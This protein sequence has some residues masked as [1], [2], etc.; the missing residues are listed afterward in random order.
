MKMPLRSRRFTLCA[1]DFGQ[2]RPINAAIIELIRVWRIGATSA[3]SQGPA[4]PEG[5]RALRDYQQLTDVGLHLNLTH[6]F[7][8]QKGTRPLAWW[9][10]AAPRGWIKREQV[11]DS[12]LSQIDLFFTHFGRL[13]DYLD[14]HQ[15]V[16]A[17]PV[18][19]EVTTEL[20]S[21]CWRGRPRPWVRTPDCLLDSGDIALKGWVL[22]RAARG[23]ADHVARDGLR[24]TKKFA[25]LYSL[26][27]ASDYPKL[28]RR[29]LHQLPSGTMLMCHPGHQTYD[30]NDP[31]REARYAEYQYLN[32]RGLSD[33]CAAADVSLVKFADLEAS[34]PSADSR[35]PAT[36]Y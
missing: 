6:R 25:G 22:K 27:P 34:S 11:R 5:A 26:D 36:R 8:G 32:Y 24:H 28:M 30:L 21:E 35:F 29:W 31:I 14:G 3:M 16:H 2:S 33:D 18:I 20:I 7:D 19:R 12:F 17:F 10:L 1:E 15:H 4:W 9:L 13:P 23:F